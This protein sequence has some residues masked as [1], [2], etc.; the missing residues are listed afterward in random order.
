MANTYK[1]SKI[2]FTSTDNTVVYTTPSNSRAIIQNILVNDDSGS[3][4]SLN[5]TLVSGANTF[6]LFKSKAISGN[7]SLE[8]ITKPIILE[9][10]E[11]LKAQ[12]TTAD[13]LHMVVSLLEISRSDQNG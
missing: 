4:D 5:V 1:N 12:A 10:N 6:S 8:L 13:R 2:D 9:E 11:I 7:A 3:G